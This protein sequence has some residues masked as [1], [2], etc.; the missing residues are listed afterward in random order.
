MHFM[1]GLG[2]QLP[3]KSVLLNSIIYPMIGADVNCEL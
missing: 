1:V 2:W 3:V